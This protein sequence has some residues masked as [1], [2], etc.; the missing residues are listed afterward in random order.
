[1]KVALI[2]AGRNV[3][4]LGPFIAKYLAEAGASVTAVLTSRAVSASQAALG[5]QAYG[6]EAKPFCDI[7]QLLSADRPEALVIA[8]PSASHLDYL[9]RGLG[10]SIHILCEKPFIWPAPASFGVL[11]NGLFD[12]AERRD[13]V[14]AMNSQWPFVLESYYELC[15]R[16]NN[17]ERFEMRLSPSCAGEAMLPDSLPHALSLLYASLGPGEIANV[18]LSGAPAAQSVCFDYGHAGGTCRCVIELVQTLAQPRPFGFGFDGRLVEREIDIQNYAIYFR[19]AGRRLNVSDPLKLSV[20]D[21]VASVR[22][23][24]EPLIGRQHIQST[25][26]MLETIYNRGV[27]GKDQEPRA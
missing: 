3:N 18:S 7:D 13:L 26:L 22:D 12:V 25:S 9:R 16:P 15:G 6:I 24:R 23:R 20:D 1:M 19:G 14:V 4:G 8:S 21:F 10:E 27:H 5:L 17:P 11:L 2:G